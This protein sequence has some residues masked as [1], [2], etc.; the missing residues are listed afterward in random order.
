M[1]QESDY[2]V[3]NPKLIAGYLTDLFKNRCLISAY[4]G[5]NNASFLTAIINLDPKSNILKLD[6]G[7]SELL[8]KQLLN[9]EKVLFRTEMDG[10]K[11][12]FSTQNIKKSKHAN[13][14]A[15]EMPFPNAM[16]WM[17]RRQYYRVKVPLSHD[18]NYCEIR[19]N[20]KANEEHQQHTE[21][22]RFKLHDLSV[23]GFSF[24]CSDT[25][26]QANFASTDSPF[27]GMLHLHEGSQARIVFLVKNTI[28]I[29]TSP[30]TTQYRLGCLFTEISPAFQSGI[31]V[32]MQDIERLRKNIG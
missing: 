15:F 25:E 3:R 31:Q 6:W 1:E 8:N 14:L 26:F 30:T 16:F 12:S 11:V 23:S 9:S 32:Y 10:I 2:L 22:V 27:E 24:L 29:K 5:T 7:P 19:F 17:Q 18:K 28:N 13:T 20:R 4:F 21:I